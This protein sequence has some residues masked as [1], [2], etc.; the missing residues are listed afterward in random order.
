MLSTYFLDTLVAPINFIAV[1]NTCLEVEIGR[2]DRKRSY[3]LTLTLFRIALVPYKI[4]QR[5]IRQHQLNFSIR[6][7]TEIKLFRLISVP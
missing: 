2:D 3:T 7:T 6:Y 4:S 5:N 1:E